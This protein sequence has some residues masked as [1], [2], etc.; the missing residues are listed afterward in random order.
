[1]SK[2]VSKN[3]VGNSDFVPTYFVIKKKKMTKERRPNSKE[4]KTT[5]GYL[6]VFYKLKIK[7]LRTSV[8]L[9]T[10]LLQANLSEL[11]KLLLKRAGGR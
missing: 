7:V 11:W 2:S 5:N 4:N 9:Q 10:Y 8:C 3:C 6:R 1:M